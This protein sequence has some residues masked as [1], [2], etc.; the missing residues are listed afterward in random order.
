VA[1][2]VEDGKGKRELQM[3]KLYDDGESA[4]LKQK[5][6]EKFVFMAESEAEARNWMADIRAYTLDEMPAPGAVATSP[7][8]PTPP[9]ASVAEPGAST[10][11]AGGSA[12]GGG[13]EGT[14]ARRVSSSLT[15]AGRVST[16]D[17]LKVV[18]T[19]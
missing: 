2:Y 5:E 14:R 19:G 18:R 11:A 15:R 3:V 16:S 8:P 10:S 7:A 12:A 9:P 1:N 13:A 6:R 17:A 4:N